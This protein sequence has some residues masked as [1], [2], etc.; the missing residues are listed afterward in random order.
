MLEIANLP[1]HVLLLHAVVVLAPITGLAGILYAVRSGWRGVLRWPVAILAVVTAGLAVLT[2]SAGEA[3]EKALPA[4][5]LIEEHAEQGDLLKIV[6][7][8]FVVV[9]LALIGLTWPRLAS[10]VPLVAKIGAHRWVVIIVQIAAV[11]V[12]LFLIYQTVATGHSGAQATWAD[13]RTS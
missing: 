3:L 2:A 4:S 7:I 1:A 11:L 10:A 5:E 13:W 9:M 6:A 8:A 12:G